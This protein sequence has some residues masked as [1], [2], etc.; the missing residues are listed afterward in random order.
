MAWPL[1]IKVFRKHITSY[2]IRKSFIFA[3]TRF[4]FWAPEVDKTLMKGLEGFSD[5]FWFCTEEAIK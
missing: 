3:V 4:S 1:T 2:F 5:I